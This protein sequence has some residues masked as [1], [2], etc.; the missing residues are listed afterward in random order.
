M[1]FHNNKLSKKIKR[2]SYPHVFTYNSLK[3][4]LGNKP[5]GGRNTKDGKKKIQSV[6]NIKNKISER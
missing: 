5:L 4:A 3:K 2:V 6:K 1:K